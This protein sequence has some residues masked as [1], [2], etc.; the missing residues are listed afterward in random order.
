[1]LSG[2]PSTLKTSATWSLSTSLRA[3]ST[4]LGGE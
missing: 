4:A 2:V 3:F 1:M